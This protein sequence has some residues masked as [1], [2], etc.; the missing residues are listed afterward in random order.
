MNMLN[1][2]KISEKMYRIKSIGKQKNYRIKTISIIKN[3]LGFCMKGAKQHLDE[4]LEGDFDF[5]ID[6]YQRKTYNSLFED[7]EYIELEENNMDIYSSKY[8]LLE[9]QQYEEAVE[10]FEKLGDKE[11]EYVKT[12]KRG[13]ICRAD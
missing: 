8:Q 12:L 6:D 10:W 4:M 3:E 1:N 7:V 2:L 13:M 5:D 11:K 9:S